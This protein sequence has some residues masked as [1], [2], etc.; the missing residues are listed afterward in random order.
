MNKILIIE[1]AGRIGS[2]LCAKLPEA[3]H[4]VIAVDTIKYD[5]NSLS[6][7]F[8]FDKFKFFNS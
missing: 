7:L 8:Y 1:T 4:I 2:M 5:K 3:G 6:H